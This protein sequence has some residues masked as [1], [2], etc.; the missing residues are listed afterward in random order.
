MLH[1]HAQSFVVVDWVF[2]ASYPWRYFEL[3]SF[4]TPP[5]GATSTNSKYISGIFRIETKAQL[6]PSWL[7]P[8]LCKLD[9]SGGLCANLQVR[10]SSAWEC[11]A[12]CVTVKQKEHLAN[13]YSQDSAREDAYRNAEGRTWRA[14]FG[15]LRLLVLH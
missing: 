12:G 11:A 13:P 4:F 7:A 3:W 5:F 14:T 8:F 2:M 9:K 15:C 1:L 6:E 10:A